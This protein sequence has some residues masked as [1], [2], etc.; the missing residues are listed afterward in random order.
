MQTRKT[1]AR[2]WS[3]TKQAALSRLRMAASQT[4]VSITTF[5]GSLAPYLA[6]DASEGFVGREPGGLLVGVTNPAQLLHRI[7]FGV[8]PFGLGA[9]ARVV[10]GTRLPLWAPRPP[11]K[12]RGLQPWSDPGL[13]GAHHR[14]NLPRLDGY[15]KPVVYLTGNLLTR[16]EMRG[17]VP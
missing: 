14:P 3:R 2:T 11:S 12:E 16:H 10:R 4:L 6:E 7:G 5:A 1:R 9:G 15:H 13:R 17:V 8:Y